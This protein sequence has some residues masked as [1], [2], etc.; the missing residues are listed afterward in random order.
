MSVAGLGA[1]C[2]ITGVKP[3]VVVF[4]SKLYPWIATYFSLTLATNVICTGTSN[5]FFPP[6]APAY[7][8]T[9]ALV[10]C[11]I[12]RSQKALSSVN[13][14]SSLTPVMITVVESGAIYSAALLSVTVAYAT[15][16]NGQ[17]AAL[18][19]VR[20]LCFSLWSQ[21]CSLLCILYICRSL[22]L[23]CVLSDILVCSCF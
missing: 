2:I 15:K 10:A 11:K 19:F 12:W 4:T 23:S 9:I 17:Y 6:C 3:G 20:Y 18:D 16:N 13:L 21:Y 1:T 14:K 22:R 8:V 5:H 7:V